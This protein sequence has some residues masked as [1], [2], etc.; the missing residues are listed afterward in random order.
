MRLDAV[1]QRWYVTFTCASTVRVRVVRTSH[2]SSRRRLLVASEG[3]LLF[4]IRSS[5]A[6][7]LSSHALV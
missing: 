3:L 5:T 1:V 4:F 2:M 7:Q 6:P